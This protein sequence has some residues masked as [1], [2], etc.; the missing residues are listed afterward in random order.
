[1]EMKLTSN[2]IDGAKNDKTWDIPHR[3]Q[4][5]SVGAKKNESIGGDALQGTTIYL[6]IQKEYGIGSSPIAKRHFMHCT[7]MVPMVQWLYVVVCCFF[8]SHTHYIQ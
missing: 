3:M 5:K 2:K 1:M 4:V 6:G 8:S 7:Q